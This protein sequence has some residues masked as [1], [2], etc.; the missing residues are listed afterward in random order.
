[1]TKRLSLS[2]FLS[3]DCRPSMQLPVV[4]MAGQP[5]IIKDTLEEAPNVMQL[6]TVTKRFDGLAPARMVIS[7]RGLR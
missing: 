7:V 3:R 6:I 1:V 5:R 4:I 2:L